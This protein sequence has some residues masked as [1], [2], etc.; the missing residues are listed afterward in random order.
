MRQYLNYR[1]ESYDMHQVSLISI[2]HQYQARK[3]ICSHFW[4][5]VGIAYVCV[6]VCARLYT[7]DAMGFQH[8]LLAVSTAGFLVVSTG[9]VLFKVL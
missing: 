8:F 9:P 6:C 2:R 7:V 4:L 5:T 1:K 3:K